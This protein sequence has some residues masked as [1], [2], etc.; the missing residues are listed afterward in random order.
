MFEGDFR[1]AHAWVVDVTTKQA[2]RITEG[3]DYTVQGAPSWSPDGKQFV[4]GAATTPMLRDNRRDVYLADV[5][6]EARSRRSAPTGATTARRAGR[7]TARRSRGSAS[8][9][10]RR[11][12]PDG[13]ASGVVMQQRLMLYDV[14]A[15]TIKDT[16]TPAFDSDAGNPVWTNEGKRVMFVTG[17]RAYNEA[18]AYDLT[19]GTY[20]QLSQK[21]TI[22]GTSISKDGRTIVVTMD[23]PDSATEIYVTDPSF[24]NLK[25]LT[26]TNPQLA[27]VA[28]GRD[29]SR[30]LE[31]QRRRRS[32]RRAA[33]AGRI[34]NPASAIRRWSSRTAVPRARM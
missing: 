23:A 31:E 7:R 34:S 10:P 22:N 28:A 11:R 8:R 5:A 6:T 2:T 24:A 21:R 4:F 19:S 30:H 1:F 14:K 26:N 18:F 12:M 17:K 16:L 20:T 3:T 32:R 9:T 29:G 27:D 15:K 33:E 25:R 13:T